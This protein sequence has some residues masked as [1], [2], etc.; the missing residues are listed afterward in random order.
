MFRS[1]TPDDIER[2]QDH[3]EKESVTNHANNYASPPFTHSSSSR[4][5]IRT[6]PI[7]YFPFG[8]RPFFVWYFFSRSRRAS[9]VSSF[10]HFC[11]ST[12]RCSTSRMS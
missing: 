7:G 12:D 4:P 3:G 2:G 5:H 8:R 6:A 10:S 9:S 1:I 11:S